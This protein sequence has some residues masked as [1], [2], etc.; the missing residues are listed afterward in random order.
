M[1][2]N[3]ATTLRAVAEPKPDTLRSPFERLN[4][5]T[6]LAGWFFF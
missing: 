5:L 1:Y 3:I 2:H 4:L 6:S